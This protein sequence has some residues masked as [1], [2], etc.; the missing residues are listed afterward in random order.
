MKAHQK[1]IV[2]AAELA[3]K[4]NVAVSEGIRITRDDVDQ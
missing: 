1:V 4:G 3:A 2:S